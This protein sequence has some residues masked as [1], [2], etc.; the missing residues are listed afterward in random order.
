MAPKR[1]IKTTQSNLNNAVAGGKSVRVGFTNN[2]A[3]RMAEYSRS[4]IQGTMYI[5]PT[6]NGRKAENK[7]LNAQFSNNTSHKNTQTK[8]NISNGKSGVV[9]AIVSKS[10]K[11]TK[12]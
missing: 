3:R 11:S 7:L 4:G 6:M 8:S 1:I 10:G 9:Y 12:S 2:A 5:A